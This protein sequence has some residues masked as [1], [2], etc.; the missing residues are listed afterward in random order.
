MI[1]IIDYKSGNIGSI[2][3]ALDRLDTKY[4][5]SNDIDK[6]NLADK[7]IFPGVGS[8]KF[9]MNNLEENKLD[10]FLIQTKIDVLGICLGLQMLFKSSEEDET[11]CLNIIEGQVRKFDNSKLPVPQIGWNNVKITIDDN[12][13]FKN[14]KDNSYFYFVHSYYAPLTVETIGKTNYGIEFSSAIKKNNI[15]AVQFHP[16]K[17]GIIGEQLLKN[18]ITL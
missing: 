15:Y 14:I 10:E 9:A 12:P 17:S 6:L 2:K 1:G 3:N 7:I 18:F 11:N 8:A 4:F 16:E 5:L 13:L